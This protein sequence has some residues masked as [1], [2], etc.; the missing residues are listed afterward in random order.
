MKRICFSFN[1]LFF[2]G[3]I[4]SCGPL[5]GVAVGAGLC[6]EDNGGCDPNVTCEVNNQGLVRCGPCPDGF[7]GR[8]NTQCNDIDDNVLGTSRF[9]MKTPS[10]KTDPATISVSVTM[11]M[12]VMV[13]LVSIL[14]SV[15]RGSMI[16]KKASRA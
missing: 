13:K 8:G 7:E 14:M 1:L 5:G 6:D 10:V 9:V 15:S 4:T 16:V 11:V 2:I 12:L 3:L